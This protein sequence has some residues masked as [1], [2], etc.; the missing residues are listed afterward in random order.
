MKI[1][2]IDNPGARREQAAR[3][4]R[5]GGHSVEEYEHSQAEVAIRT[6]PPQILLFAVPESDGPALLRTLCAADATGGMY[7]VSIVGEHHADR[8]AS[9]IVAAGSH[10]VLCAPYSEEELRLR[11]DVHTRMRGWSPPP[12]AATPK[13][14]CSLRDARAWQF[15]GD[16]VADDLEAMLGRPLRLTERSATAPATATRLAMIPMILASEYLE[17]CI[18]IGAADPATLTWLRTHVLGDPGAADAMVGD[19]LRE[20]ANVAGG[21]VKRAIVPEGIALSTGIPVDGGGTTDYGTSA[22]TWRVELEGT[23]ALTVIAHIRTRANRRVPARVL[24]EGMVVIGDVRNAAGMLLLPAG[25]RL[26]STTADRLGKLLDSSLIEVS[27]A[28]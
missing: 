13:P 25:T 19:M 7:V 22:R 20:M 3:L 8:M 24:C 12:A 1:A 26:T 28:A 11:V 4:F 9:S 2:I 17:L 10:D 23:A 18:S 27:S 14:P 5:E 21:A 6:K 15:L 16:I